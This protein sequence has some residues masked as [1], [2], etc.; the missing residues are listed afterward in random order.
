MS[1]IYQLVQ[2]LTAESDAA[3]A[4]KAKSNQEGADLKERLDTTAE[5]VINGTKNKANKNTAVKIKM[6]D[7]TIVIDA[8][9]ESKKQKAMSNN[10]LEGKMVQVL[11]S[12]I[13][14]RS[15][16]DERVLIA[17]TALLQMKQYTLFKGHCLEAFLF[18]A[19]STTATGTPPPGLQM[20]VEDMGGLTM[21]I[22]FYCCRDD[23][24]EPTKFKNL[25]EE[26]DIPAKEARIMLSL[27]HI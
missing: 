27:I 14:K 1:E 9:R 26:F 17:E 7:G 4:L 16:A 12:I 20:K 3:E 21:L 6:A 15:E 2:F 25:M 24:F 10:T 23:N 19:F 18:E 13:S 5:Q 11:D 22:E 8:E